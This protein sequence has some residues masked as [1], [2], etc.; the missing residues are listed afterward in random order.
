MSTSGGASGADEARR[1]L[2]VAVDANGSA[3]GVASSNSKMSRKRTKTGCLTC[4]KRRIKCG[5]ERPICN[6]CIKSKR[7]CEGYNQRVVFKPPTMDWRTA[8]PGAAD[9]IPYHSG[10]IP[11]RPPGHHT[12]QPAMMGPNVTL[13]HIRPRPTSDF[14]F[15]QLE[16]GSGM[17]MEPLS[18]GG[19]ESASAQYR[20]QFLNITVPESPFQPPHSFYSPNHPGNHQH[21]LSH[22]SHGLPTPAY[23]HQS[24]PTVMNGMGLDLQIQLQPGSL[25]EPA[26][27][28]MPP[29]YDGATSVHY[30]QPP[31]QTQI[32]RPILDNKPPLLGEHR[33][34]PPLHD[35][36]RRSTQQFGVTADGWRSDYGQGPLPSPALSQGR[37]SDPRSLEGPDVKNVGYQPSTGMHFPFFSPVSFRIPLRVSLSE[38][39]SCLIGLPHYGNACSQGNFWQSKMYST[40]HWTDGSLMVTF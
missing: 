35:H 24:S 4:R 22:Q 17:P 9:M 19:H 8:Q 12:I 15:S 10:I 37:G 3:S 13:A 34:S 18:G 5:E 27:S 39:C 6:N 20:E 21:D 31:F 26:I 28:T 11:G 1:D 29:G 23:P 32:T 25:P 7:H 38:L 2:E 14:D 30:S 40:A 36:S 16:P 33:I